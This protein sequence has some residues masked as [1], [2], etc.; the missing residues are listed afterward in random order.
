M[1]EVTKYKCDHCG[2]TFTG[3]SYCLKHE[4][5]C[6]H[7]S[8]NRACAS[9]DYLFSEIE[10]DRLDDFPVC[11]KNRDVQTTLQHDCTDWLERDTLEMEDRIPLLV[12]VDQEAAKVRNAQEHVRV[13]NANREF[14]SQFFEFLNQKHPAGAPVEIA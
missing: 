6:Y 10:I 5:G 2:K 1:K 11:L 7:N 4:T 9:C 13:I 8:A 14:N 3:K 12:N